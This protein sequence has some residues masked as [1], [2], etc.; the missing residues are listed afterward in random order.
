M[1]TL[2]DVIEALQGIRP[3]T[4]TPEITEAVVDSRHAIPG[5]MFI[6]IKGERTDGHNFI[7][8]AFRN[9]AHIALVE[10]DIPHEFQ[11]VDLTKPLDPDASFPPLPFALKVENTTRALQK[12]AAYWR[13]RFQVRVI[14]ITGSVGKSTT[15]EL[16]AEILSQRY[17]TLK[18]QGNFNNEIGLP[19]TLLRLGPGYECVV[20]EM[21]FYQPGD[22]ELLCQIAQ[23][24]VGVLT[25]IGTVHASR[26]K[27]Q[28]AIAKG[29]SELVQAL[30]PSPEGTA[31]LN[32]DD[33][34][35]MPMASL[36]K[37][38]LFFYGL[39]PASD[40]WADEIESDGL[41]GVR[42]RLHHGGETFNLHAP[43]IG[44]HSI[45]TILRAISVALVE[46]LTWGEIITGLQQASSQLRLVVVRTRQNA[47]LLDDT[48]NAS[49]E[50]MLAAL[51]L[52]HELP[53]RR[54][55][56]LGGM[57]ELGPYEAIGH[58]K[59]GMRAAEVVDYLI[60]YQE[61]AHLILNAALEA[62]LT[63]DKTFHSDDESEIVS[64]L[65]AILCPGDVVLV[66]G[67]HSLRMDNI[68]QA[69]EVEE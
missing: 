65:D 34:F 45:H 62:G 27:S 38:S 12:I 19:L 57:N 11:L 69:L 15:K 39:D 50:S 28:E 59:V 58:Q 43:M 30:P 64:K 7:A 3:T 8:D 9:G 48:Y 36:T 6:A 1:L 35:I 41:N 55:A 40:L 37:A 14:G 44:R 23:P 33:P 21:G 49:P 31:I 66:K 56:V 10:A 2:A 53:G 47:L 42:F 13:R 54:I 46:G 63:G 32:R 5:S 29:K 60:T 17:H 67:A 18:N 24:Q 52:L 20:L 22:I 4:M 61:N 68:V 26:A 51:N 25:N 16:S